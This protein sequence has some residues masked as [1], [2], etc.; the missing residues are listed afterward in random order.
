MKHPLVRG[1]AVV[2]AVVVVIVGLK[3]F[4]LAPDDVFFP[5]ADTHVATPFGSVLVS[6]ERT[7]WFSPLLLAHLLS[8]PSMWRLC[9]RLGYSG[10]FSLAML[11]P[12]AN[13]LLLYFLAFAKWPI[14]S[15]S[16]GNGPPTVRVGARPME[17][18]GAV[19][20]L[21]PSPG[22]FQEGLPEPN[23]ADQNTAADR[24]GS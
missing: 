3:L 15:Q 17:D 20:G 16:A 18:G 2:L 23:W 13:I 1:A 5:H 22:L 10:W 19:G 24:I 7:S 9:N 14:E 12:L 6:S 11:A 21:K 8:V 4:R